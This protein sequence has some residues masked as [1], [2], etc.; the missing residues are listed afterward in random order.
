MALKRA[1]CS[2]FW[3]VSAL[4]VVRFCSSTVNSRYIA[5]NGTLNNVSV[6]TVVCASSAITGLILQV[7]ISSGF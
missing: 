7:F 5:P 2:T 3:V 1:G 6:I 4:P